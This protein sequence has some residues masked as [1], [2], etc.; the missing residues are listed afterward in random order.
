VKPEETGIARQ[1]L[2][3]NITAAT[4]TQAT[5]EVLLETTFSPRALQSCYERIEL[6]L[7]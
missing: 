3:K 2:S 6:R 5:L 1:R 4:N 7:D